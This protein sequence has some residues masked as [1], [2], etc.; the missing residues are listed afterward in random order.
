MCP[1]YEFKCEECGIVVER[2]IPTSMI[3]TG[4]AKISPCSKVDCPGIAQRIVSANSRQ[5]DN[6]EQTKSTPSS[7]TSKSAAKKLMGGR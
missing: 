6:W 1:I 2:L 7:S 4:A 3:G 5:S